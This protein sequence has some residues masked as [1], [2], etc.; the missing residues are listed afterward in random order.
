M[1]T[2]LTALLNI[3]NKF[4][5]HLYL[6]SI[7]IAHIQTHYHTK[8]INWEHFPE[9]QLAVTDWWKLMQNKIFIRQSAHA[10]DFQ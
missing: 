5:Q 9:Q 4:P 2:I 6:F 7:T 3:N 8:G 1:V 10:N